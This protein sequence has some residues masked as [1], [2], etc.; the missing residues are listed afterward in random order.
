MKTFLCE[1]IL[2]CLMAAPGARPVDELTYGT[3]LYAYYQQDYGQALLDVVVAEQRQRL[4][5]DPVRFQLARGSFA[6]KERLYR[7]AAESFA[8]VDAS[9]LDAL[10]R[11]RLAFHLARE[12]FRSRDWGALDAELAV[13]DSASGT[14]PH[15][16]VAFMQAE[17][18]L[19]RGKFAAAEHALAAV[20]PED[21]HLAYGLFNLGVAYREAGSLAEARGAF[22]R[23]GGL[24]V[25]SEPA[26]DVVQRG[27]LAL[28]VTARSS[29]DPLSAESV[30]G[31]L[32]AQ[33]RYR[34][35]ALAGF[36]RS[37]MARRDHE[38][39]ARIWLTL[40]EGEGWSPSRAAA[41]LGLPMSLERLP[42][43]A[44]ALDRY[45]DAEQ[46]FE[47]R[48][49]SLQQAADRV[50]DPVWVEA[51]LE[52]FAEAFPEA[53]G[54][55]RRQRLSHL[56]A[57]V[58]PESWLDWLAR[59]DVHRVMIEW[60]ELH[61]MAGWLR[62][63]PDTLATFQEITG[64][65]RRRA[66]RARGALADEALA[67]RR[68]ALAAEL[69]ARE[70]ELDSLARQPARMDAAWMQRLADP[71]ENLLLQR[72]QAMAA[73]VDARASGPERA[74]LAARIRRLTGVVFWRIADDRS[75]RLRELTRRVQESRRLLAD[76][77][78][79]MD[80]LA[81]AE[82]RFRAGVEADFTTLASRAQAVT[83][84]V[85]TALDVRRREVRLA[86]ERSLQEEMARTREHLL[87]A[88]IAIARATDRLAAAAS[89]EAAP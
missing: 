31:S 43:P 9:E 66:A 83:E 82:S 46:A 76:V 78:A 25:H 86:L 29:G 87:T 68:E 3:A 89:P 8:A 49:A 39:A 10:D 35:M 52:A 77:D 19:A 33:G 71:E 81:R 48:L 73:R 75:V 63:L 16:E 61:Y 4:G 51:L 21:D 17:S 27:R 38:L 85:A 69:A 23:L 88:R 34:E 42:A 7:M 58:G 70:A 26:W 41:H 50:A 54:D 5:D 79:R 36:A 28:A 47:G 20:D 80:R 13:L 59:E 44:H 32:P 11:R 15:P 53:D 62:T 84:Q 24:R 37:A 56:D 1:L 60:R 14:G 55:R 57:G 72:L 2:S 18:A 22:A 6:F 65:R 30:L 74:R 67:G 12:H 64:E 40:L 45:R